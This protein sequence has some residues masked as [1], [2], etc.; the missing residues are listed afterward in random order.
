MATAFL[1][2]SKDVILQ[3]ESDDIAFL[4]GPRKDGIIKRH[5]L[6]PIPLH[7]NPYQPLFMEGEVSITFNTDAT[8]TDETSSSYAVNEN[9]VNNK[10][11]KKKG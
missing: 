6:S 4:I 11:Q 9:G 3:K 8:M 5:Q 2:E 7:D 1:N 10:Q